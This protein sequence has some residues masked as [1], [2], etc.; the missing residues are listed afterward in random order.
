[1]HAAPPRDEAS[2]KSMQASL[3]Q[4]VDLGQREGGTLAHVGV[5][6]AGALPHGKELDLDD[7]RNADAGH[8]AQGQRADE[9]IAR[10]Q[11]LLEAI[12]TEQRELSARRRVIR[13]VHQIDIHHL[14]DLDALGDH[15]FYDGGEEIRHIPSFGYHR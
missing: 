14:L 1:M 7:V 13:V 5:S 10:R 6:V 15:V 9:L 11:V 2:K 3:T 8:D 4:L 12:D